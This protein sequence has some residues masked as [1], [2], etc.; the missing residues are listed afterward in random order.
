MNKS[1]YKAYRRA[2]RAMVLGAA[3]LSPAEMVEKA[4]AIANASEAYLTKR[5]NDEDA[6]DEAKRQAWE[7]EAT[8]KVLRIGR[9]LIGTETME[10]LSVK[11]VRGGR[12]YF[13]GGVFADLA[14]VDGEEG[15]TPAPFETTAGSG[16]GGGV[17]VGVIHND[18]A[19]VQLNADGKDPAPAQEVSLPSP[20]IPHAFV[21]GNG[22]AGGTGVPNPAAGGGSN[23]Q[24]PHGFKREPQ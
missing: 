5:G 18:G 17:G 10:Y 11:E 19:H 20:H 13:D 12:V 14:D 15:F 8:E 2:L 7:K 24:G 6:A 22:G 4:G 3:R 16:S 21:A 23:G 1:W 9:Y